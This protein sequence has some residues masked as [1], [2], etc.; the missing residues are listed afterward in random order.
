MNAY[1]S[2]MILFIHYDL[3]ISDLRVRFINSILQ[4]CGLTMVDLDVVLAIEFFSLILRQA[5]KGVL[6]WRKDCSWN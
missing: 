1:H 4:R 2:F 6:S 5:Y 3:H